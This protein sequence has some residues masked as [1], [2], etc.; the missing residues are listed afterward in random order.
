MSE[1][2]MDFPS[3]VTTTT[4]NVSP[5]FEEFVGV[6]IDIFQDFLWLKKVDLHNDEPV[7]DGWPDPSLIHGSDFITIHDDILDTMKAWGIVF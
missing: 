3:E 1:T 4:D 7:A 5:E 2:F 6:I